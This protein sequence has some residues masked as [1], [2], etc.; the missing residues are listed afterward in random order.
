MRVN[1]FGAAYPPQGRRRQG[2]G[3]QGASNQGAN[4]ADR[5][6]KAQNRGENTVTVPPEAKETPYPEP[7]IGEPVAAAYISTAEVIESVRTPPTYPDSFFDVPASERKAML[8]KALGT[9]FDMEKDGLLDGLTKGEIYNKLKAVFTSYLGED[10]FD[11][12]TISNGFAFGAWLEPDDHEF[13]KSAWLEFQRALWRNDF[14]TTQ[15]S[16]DMIEARGFTGK[17]EDEMRAAVRAQFPEQMTF[18]EVILM[19][20]ELHNLGVGD[21]IARRVQDTMLFTLN[22]H[23]LYVTDQVRELMGALLDMP[24]DYD[25]MKSAWGAFETNS[26]YGRSFFNPDSKSTEDK[27]AKMMSWF[28][29]QVNQALLAQLREMLNELEVIRL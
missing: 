26:P 24:A 2:T 16:A 18:R 8:I 19:S 29:S 28:G 27:L 22:V 25:A 3:Q 23:P 1:S 14:D 5:L 11:L 12:A 4:F 15:G 6:T 10:L 7:A 9:V 20:D 17:S 13:V 21:G